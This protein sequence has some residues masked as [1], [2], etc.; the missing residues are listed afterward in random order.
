MVGT[1]LVP[2]SG[3]PELILHFLSLSA[4]SSQGSPGS[5]WTERAREHF[6][7]GGAQLHVQQE[8]QLLPRGGGETESHQ[9]TALVEGVASGC[10]CVLM[11]PQCGGMHRVQH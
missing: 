11:S 6:E 7:S 4:G 9:I 1:M 3:R 5:M 8:Q 2:L 10:V